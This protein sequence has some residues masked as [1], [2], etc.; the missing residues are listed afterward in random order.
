[1]FW[2]Y[3]LRITRRRLHVVYGV[4]QGK[5]FLPTVGDH[6]P[7]YDKEGGASIVASLQLCPAGGGFDHT[8]GP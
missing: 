5:G 2:K 6:N 7:T 8:K 3:R 1:M 4:V